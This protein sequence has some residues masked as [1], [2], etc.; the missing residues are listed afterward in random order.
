MLNQVN[1]MQLL[2]RTMVS[3]PRSRNA[4]GSTLALLGLAALILYCLNL[5]GLPLR[6][7]D[8]GTYGIVA[9]EMVQ[10][11]NWL[12]PTL[13]GQPFEFKPPLA[14]WLIASSYALMGVSEWSSRLPLAMISAM[15]VPLLY[16]VGRQLFTQR[17]PAL[18]SA[19]V[20]LTCL[21]VLRH[22]RLAM[23]DGCAISFFLLMLLCLLKAR[24]SPLWAIGAGISLGLILMTKGILGL[25]LGAIAVVF[26]VLQGELKIFFNPYLWLGAALGLAPVVGWYLA[27]GLQ[28]GGEFWRIHFL[29]QSFDRVWSAVD[30]N[31]APPWMY[32]KE[33]LEYYWPWAIFLPGG[34]W[35]SWQQRQTAWGRLILVGTVG[36]LGII[37]VMTTKLPWYVLPVY[38]FLA[39]AVGAQLALAQDTFTRPRKRAYP[40]AWSGLLLLLALVGLVGGTTIAWLETRPLLFGLGIVVSLTMGV[41]AYLS[42]KGDRQF[43]WVLLGGTY[44]SLGIFVS[45]NFWLWEL[46]EAFAVKP[47][48]QLVKTHT[49]ANA[50]VYTSFAYSRPSLDFYSQ[51]PVVAVSPNQ[52][53]PLSPTKPYLLIDADTLKQLDSSKYQTLGSAENFTLIAVKS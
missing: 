14:L 20:Y 35:L 17:S 11:G 46:N 21:P 48:A 43:V 31:T 16:A 44:L 36:F 3:T 40:I 10:S 9:R 49:P 53:Q 8:E 13:A 30:G 51:R 23:M 18:L 28:Y 41:A 33:I 12:H 52:L 38:P 19:L 6:D 22:G 4:E 1:L 29:N 37:S 47:V 42:Y 7:W 26:M 24:R 2:N 32:L 5:G 50:T 45:S 39:L 15:A 27:Q 25:L 34:L